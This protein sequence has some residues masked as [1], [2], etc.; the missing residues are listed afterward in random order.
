MHGVNLADELDEVEGFAGAGEACAA[1]SLAS[2]PQPGQPA[3]PAWAQR[4]TAAGRRGCYRPRPCRRFLHRQP[5][6]VGGR[7]DS[8]ASG[9]DRLRRFGIGRLR[10]VDDRCHHGACGVAVGFAC[11]CARLGPH[12]WKPIRS[13]GCRCPARYGDAYR[14]VGGGRTCRAGYRGRIDARRPGRHA[15]GTCRGPEKAELMA[16]PVE[17]LLDVLRRES[18]V[19]FV[20]TSVF[21]G[22]AVAAAVAAS[23]RCP[24]RRRCGGI[25]RDIR[26]ARH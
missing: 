10:Q 4:V 14:A 21:W 20:D 11:R 22:D 3:M 23:D 16:P 1:A 19:V 9:T 26:F 7:F 18:D 5:R 15:L 25:V 24:G 2:E 6:A 12:V 8:V 13:T 17:L